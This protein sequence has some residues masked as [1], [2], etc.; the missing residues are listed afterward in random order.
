MLVHLKPVGD[1]FVYI[2]IKEGTVM[3]AKIGG[4]ILLLA[5]LLIFP[6]QSFAVDYWISDVKI[7][8]HLQK[9]GTVHVI[10]EHTYEFE[11]E[12][13]GITRTVIPKEGSTITDFTATENGSELQIEKEDNLYKIHRKGEDETITVTLAY[14]IEKGLEFYQ[15]V[16]QFYWPFFDSRNESTYGD[17]VITV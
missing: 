17:L 1:L 6:I 13:N 3:K 16:A 12:F 5:F 9:D 15:D 14:T 11:G 7:D 2:S 8:A 4:F 10:E